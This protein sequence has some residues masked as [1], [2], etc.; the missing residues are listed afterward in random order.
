VYVAL[1]GNPEVVE[2]TVLEA[3]KLVW[4]IVPE[5]VYSPSAPFH[6]IVVD[7]QPVEHD[8]V[9][10]EA[11]VEHD[12][13]HGPLPATAEATPVAHNCA[14]VVGADARPTPFALP[15][16]AGVE[17]VYFT[18]GT[19]QLGEKFSASRPE[20]V[21]VAISVQGPPALGVHVKV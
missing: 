3:F 16:V 2:T 11:S 7:V 19:P 21:A 12:H 1:P 13:V 20:K 4:A 15:H 5:H 18:D 17:L 6:V 9:G 8:A 14:L 10:I